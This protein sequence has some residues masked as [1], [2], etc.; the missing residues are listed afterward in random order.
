MD[1]EILL[2]NIAEDMVKNRTGY[3]GLRTLK[4]AVSQDGINGITDFLHGDAILGKLK[5][6][7]IIIGWVWSKIVVVF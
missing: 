4:L 3:S 5:V 7:V 2:K 1:I 6:T